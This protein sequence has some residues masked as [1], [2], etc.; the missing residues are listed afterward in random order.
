MSGSIVDRFEIIN[1]DKGESKWMLITVCTCFFVSEIF[2]ERTV[3][4]QVRKTVSQCGSFRIYEESSHVPNRPNKYA[5]FQAH[6]QCVQGNA[7]QTTFGRENPARI[8]EIENKVM[9]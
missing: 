4:S 8:N 6:H 2:I 9:D 1:I 5:A 3:I 7:R